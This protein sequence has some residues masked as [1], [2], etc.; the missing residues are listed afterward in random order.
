LPYRFGLSYLYG[1]RG[2]KRQL[3]QNLGFTVTVSIALKDKPTDCLIGFNT[4][5]DKA[6]ELDSA[7]HCGAIAWQG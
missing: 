6:R 4:G 2:D 1:I 3:G 7:E 5:V